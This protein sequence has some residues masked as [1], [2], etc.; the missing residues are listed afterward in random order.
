SYPIWTTQTDAW[1]Y[2]IDYS[3]G[4]PTVNTGPAGLLRTYQLSGGYTQGPLLALGGV[5]GLLGGFGLTRR[6]R[7]PSGIRSATM[8]AATMALAILSF[9]AVFEFSWR[10]Q[11]P[12]LVLL[13]L[14]GILGVTTWL[15]PLRRPEPAVRRGVLAPFPD[16]VD[17]PAA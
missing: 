16:L 8:L 13:P 17:W 5:V 9:S 6:G 7:G 14:A 12:G 4:P 2:S 11:L 10:Y 15:G 1:L 3:G